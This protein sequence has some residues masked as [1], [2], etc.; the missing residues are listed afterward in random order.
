[1][2]ATMNVADLAQATVKIYALE[3]ARMDVEQDAK[4]FVW[5]P[6]KVVVKQ[7]VLLDVQQDALMH[8]LDLLVLPFYNIILL[9]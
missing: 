1:M 5:V 9:S 8:A 4:I 3:V 6:A 2:V 7:D